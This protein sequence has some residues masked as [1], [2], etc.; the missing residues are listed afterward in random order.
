MNEYVHAFTER[1]A[2]SSV[3]PV[4]LECVLG[5]YVFTLILGL[6]VLAKSSS[7]HPSIHS[8]V[9][10]RYRL[11]PVLDARQ[12]GPESLQNQICPRVPLAPV[13]T[14]PLLQPIPPDRFRTISP[15]SSFPVPPSVLAQINLPATNTFRT[16]GA[17]AHP[18][19]SAQ[20][21]PPFRHAVYT[22]LSSWRTPS[23]PA[24]PN[25]ELL[26]P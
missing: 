16:H 9:T 21:I 15:G 6:L 3:L 18:P 17:T 23:H 14:S 20:A 26:S 8:T 2:Q 11:A 5:S 13:T 25:P 24:K 4:I 10:S 22:R 19:A 7:I 12:G 1:L